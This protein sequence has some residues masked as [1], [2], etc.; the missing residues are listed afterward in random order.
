MEKDRRF[1]EQLERMYRATMTQNQTDLAA[2]LGI[3]QSSISCAKRRA[4]IPAEWLLTLLLKCDVNSVWI[5]SGNGRQYV[6]S[7]KGGYESDH[8]A[9]SRRPMLS[10][11]RQLPSRMLADELVRRIAA[12]TNSENGKR[13]IRGK[14]AGITHARKTL[15]CRRL[16]GDR[17][18]QG[19]EL[20]RPFF[21]PSAFHL[22]VRERSVDSVQHAIA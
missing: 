9:K 22:L 8:Q 20:A 2:Y 7:L 11:L 5:L 18:P 13:V 12:R 17:R 16:L 3:R 10:L 19:V 14:P 1:A 4:K 6:A 21:P 15:R